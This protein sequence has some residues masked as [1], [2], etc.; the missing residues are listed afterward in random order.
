M[1]S[2]AVAVLFPVPFTAMKKSLVPAVVGVPEITPV[3]AAKL[4]PAGSSPE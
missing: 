3:L 2:A 1:L 4:N